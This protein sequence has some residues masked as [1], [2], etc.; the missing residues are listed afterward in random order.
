MPPVRPTDPVP[1]WNPPDDQVEQPSIG[2]RALGWV[3]QDT[4]PSKWLNA[5]M[6]STGR[7]I[8]YLASQA[9]IAPADG[10]SGLY[11]EGR[12]TGSGLYGKGGPVGGRGVQG[13]G[14]GVGGSGGHFEG[15]PATTSSSGG[16]PGVYA[17]GTGERAAVEAFAT[18]G[19]TGPGLFAQAQG[20]GGAAIMVGLGDLRY[21]NSGPAFTAAKVNTLTAMNT[22]K[23]LVMLITG[24]AGSLV[25]GFNVSGVAYISSTNVRCNF[26]ADFA[27]TNYIVLPNASAAPLFYLEEVQ[28]S[29]FWVEFRVKD[30]AAN[31]IQN[32]TTLNFKIEF[33]VFGRQ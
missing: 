15:A 5:L 14:G 27:S 21:N 10:S 2:R 31:A 26:S 16:A 4:V 24:P 29:Q 22:P 25:D 3:F 33:A 32:L 1:D 17:Q 6:R 19:H 9:Y 7:W 30:Y 20:G 28:R 23:V 11:A 13:L 12:T 18:P 8:N